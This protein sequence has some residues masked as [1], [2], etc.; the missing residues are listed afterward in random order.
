MISEGDFDGAIEAMNIPRFPVSI[1][2][3][4]NALIC[5]LLIVRRSL[6]G[7]MLLHE[8]NQFLGRPTF[9]LE[10]III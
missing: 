8:R 7:L 2:Q 6:I 9:G 5:A 1:P 10:V 4:I 3:P